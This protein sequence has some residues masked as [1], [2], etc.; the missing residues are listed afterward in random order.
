[1]T[2][3][4]LTARVTRDTCALGAALTAP[5]A[6]LG[7]IIINLLTAHAPQFYDVA[8]RDFGLLLGALTL[9]RLATAV[10]AHGSSSLEVYNAAA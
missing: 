1:M 5:A 9:A 8:L 3:S 6:W 10:R 7:G 4:E 2:P